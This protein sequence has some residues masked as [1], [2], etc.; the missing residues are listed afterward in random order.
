MARHTQM[1]ISMLKKLNLAHGIKEHTVG[2]RGMIF[3]AFV[4]EFLRPDYLPEC[5]GEELLFNFAA[6]K[7]LA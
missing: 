3:H 7:A 5:G 4:S 6:I 2:D 1:E